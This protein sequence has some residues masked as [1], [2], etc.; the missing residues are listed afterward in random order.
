MRTYLLLFESCLR[1]NT[2]TNHPV[3][4][5]RTAHLW[6]YNITDYG[7]LRHIG[8]NN[9]TKNRM[10]LSAYFIAAS[11]LWFAIHFGV[12]FHI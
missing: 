1:V 11:G 2:T 7:F 8:R 3:G 4:S 6:L 9:E 10:Y 12:G 5:P